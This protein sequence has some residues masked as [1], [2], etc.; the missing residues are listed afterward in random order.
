MSGT[1]AGALAG[2]DT[3]RARLRGEAE[4]AT[5]VQRT[6]R[7]V[8]PPSLRG[9]RQQQQ[10]QAKTARAG[11]RLGQEARALELAN[12]ARARENVL[13]AERQRHIIARQQ[14]MQRL[15]YQLDQ[16]RHFAKSLSRRKEH[17]GL[18][19]QNRKAQE[20]LRVAIANE[21]A[22]IAELRRGGR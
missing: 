1:R 20:R 9:F 13:A 5:Q 3:R 10:T 11:G 7:G 6:V 19:A 16:L 15:Q 4:H 18:R 17:A 12:A 21:R 8:A 22:A 14:R 2:W